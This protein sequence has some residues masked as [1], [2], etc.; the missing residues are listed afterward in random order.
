MDLSANETSDTGA[1]SINEAIKVDNEIIFTGSFTTFLS[2]FLVENLLMLAT[3]EAVAI[4]SRNG[5]PRHCHLCWYLVRLRT[6]FQASQFSFHTL[7]VRSKFIHFRKNEV[8]IFYFQALPF[9]LI[10]GRR[11]FISTL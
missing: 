6:K 4:I 8:G 5:I 10:F 7:F 9:Y 11:N 3:L 2:R 1:T